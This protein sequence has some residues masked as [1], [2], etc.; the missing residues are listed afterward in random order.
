MIALDAEWGPAMRLDSVMRFPWQMSL[1]AIQDEKLIYEMGEQIANQ[2][3]ILGVNI[4]FAPVADINSNPKNPIIGNRSFGE[5]K[6]KVSKLAAAY[7]KGM[8][9]NGVLACA[10]HFIGDGGTSFGTGINGQ[11]DRGNLKISEAELRKV[12]LPPFKKAVESGVA[13]VMAAF[14]SW[15]DAS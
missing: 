8:Q 1:G 2:C 10:K 14:N 11:I 13:T 15:N 12:H 9:D 7:M 6:R 5:D 4:N 3:K